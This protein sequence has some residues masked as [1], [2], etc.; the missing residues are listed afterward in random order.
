MRFVFLFIAILFCFDAAAQRKPVTFPEKTTAGDNDAIYS[1][2]DG[3]DKKILFH[4]ARKYFLPLVNPILRDTAPPATG[5]TTLLGQFLTVDG[6]NDIYYVDGAGRALRMGISQAALDSTL[7]LALAADSLYIILGAGADPD[8]LCNVGG[9]CVTLPIGER[10]VAGTGLYEV[11]DTIHADTTYLA[12]DWAL[13]Q[14]AAAIRAELED[15]S[16]VWRDTFTDLRA[17]ITGIEATLAGV[18][19]GSGAAGQVAHFSDANTVTGSSNFVW[20]GTNVGVG[21]TPTSRLHIQTN[22]L[23]I[24]QTSSSGLLLSNST[25]AASGAQQLSPFVEFFTQA[26]KSN[27]TAASQNIRFR[28]DALGVQGTTV[29]SGLFRLSASV[30]D[31]TYIDPVVVASNGTTNGTTVSIA[32]FNGGGGVVNLGGTNGSVSFLAG[33][34]N[35][36][37]DNR[38]IF[39]SGGNQSS[40]QGWTGSA[41]GVGIGYEQR[42]TN[43]GGNLTTLNVKGTNSAST[44]KALY[45]ENSSAQPILSIRNDRAI[46]VDGYISFNNQYGASRG[47]Q[48][49][50]YSLTGTPG[51]QSTI[52][53]NAV[54]AGVTSA[55]VQKS[56]SDAGNFIRINY[57]TGIGFH[58]N[59]TSGVG[60]DVGEATNERM[61]I[62][63]AG[64]VSIGHASP[65]LTLDVRSS[66]ANTTGVFSLANSTVTTPLKQFATNATPE[67][68]ITA[69]PGDIAFANAGAAYLK[70]TGSAT[71]TGWAK[72]AT[73]TDLAGYLPLSLTGSTFLSLNGNMLGFMGS[74]TGDTPSLLFTTTGI[75]MASQI[76][77]VVNL[78]G[79]NIEMAANGRLDI[80][81]DSVVL[82]GT[83]PVNTNA[84]H[85]LVRDAGSKRLEEVAIGDVGTW[86]KPEWE[87]GPV[88]IVTDDTLTI[89]NVALS[90]FSKLTANSFQLSGGGETFSISPALMEASN[91]ALNIAGEWQINVNDGI[92]VA[93]DSY[94][95][96]FATTVNWSTLAGAFF[97]G[98]P[99][100]LEL[101]AGSIFLEGVPN[102]L[103]NTGGLGGRI[104]FREDIT[105]GNHSV[106]LAVNANLSASITHYLPTTLP[107]SAGTWYED[108]GGNIT[109]RGDETSNISGTT[110]SN[111]DITIP[112]GLGDNTFTVN[113]TGTGTTFF[114]LQPHTLTS[115][116]FKVRFF[117]ASGAALASTVVT[118]FY[119]IIDL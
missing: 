71:N 6:T 68:A 62:T 87:A 65:A 58:T 118:G 98:A 102:I 15:S 10:T 3:A 30:N 24:T 64:L 54:K 73:A 80:A 66:S 81:P 103:S 119:Q 55:S 104:N 105:N 33:Y 63:L 5:N 38:F 106:G 14:M 82:S 56:H 49:A 69:S 51:G 45:V 43:P 13:M 1:Q 53:G 83:Y 97:I 72:F 50:Y 21:G 26:Y 52:L 107:A 2:E 91:L 36:I 100:T 110:D 7:Q 29:A 25:L 86:L 44:G 41:A 31:G 88:G 4:T 12:T 95:G 35:F 34:G 85:L 40:I 101:S 60:V 112:H 111:G 28:M 94:F 61:R 48:G 96:Q 9:F 108:A 79:P 109:I 89:E 47:I 27:V 46:I 17:V 11:N 117:D 37:Q 113:A 84:T 77:T 70:E 92:Y 76:G 74:G 20:D 75:V 90:T 8:T 39:Y 57:G 114:H 116:D 78:F 99:D 16:M 23:G 67:S 19:D 59:I 42:V 32:N 93:A 115:T 22:A 18:I